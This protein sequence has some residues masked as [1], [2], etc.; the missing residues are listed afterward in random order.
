MD[1]TAFSLMLKTAQSEALPHLGDAPTWLLECHTQGA[2]PL[3]SRQ[4]VCHVASSSMNKST[5]SNSAE[6]R[7]ISASS[8]SSAHHMSRC[9]RQVSS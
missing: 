9:G 8:T 1:P 2:G 7:S 6:L 3:G 5:C 4:L